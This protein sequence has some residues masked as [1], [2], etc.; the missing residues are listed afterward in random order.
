MY[1]MLIY[2]VEEIRRKWKKS[3]YAVYWEEDSLIIKNHLVSTGKKTQTKEEVKNCQ[4]PRALTL[5]TLC[6]LKSCHGNRLGKQHQW[7]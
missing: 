6:S 5:Y 3:T 1:H 2:S 7:R 4:Q